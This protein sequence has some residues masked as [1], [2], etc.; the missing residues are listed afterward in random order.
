MV[1]EEHIERRIPVAAEVL[2]YVGGALAFAA[3]IALLS[4]FWGVMGIAGRLGVCALVAAAGL[5]GG[6]A[7]DHL[8]GATASRLKQFLFALGVAGLGAGFGLGAFEIAKSAGLTGTDASDWG[9]FTGFLT[10]AVAGGLIWRTRKTVLQHLV[11]GFSVGMSA[12]LSLPLMP[13]EGPDWGAGAVL[14]VVGV[15]WGVLGYRG[16]LPPQAAAYSLAS[17]GVLGGIEMMSVVWGAPELTFLSWALWLGLVVSVAMLA[18]GVVARNGVLLGFGS[19]GTVAFAWQVI[20]DLFEGRAVVPAGLLSVGIVFVG[21][22]FAI[23]RRRSAEELER[24]PLPAEVLGYVG[25]SLVAAGVV[26]LVTTFWGDLTSWGRVLIL[27]VPAIATL[28]AGMGISRRDEASA[29]RLGQFLCAL[30]IAGIGGAAGLTGY[31]VA[32][33]ISEPLPGAEPGELA[34]MSQS[35]GMTIGFAVAA[36][37]GG[38]VWFL[39]KGAL[40][41]LAMTAFSVMAVSTAFEIR[42]MFWFE[43]P[44]WWAS[45]TLVAIVSAAWLFLGIREVVTPANVPI[46]VGSVGLLIG[47]SS[48]YNTRG[49]PVEWMPWL[50]LA[51]SVGMLVASIPLKRYVLLGVG[52][53]GVVINAIQI[54][55]TMFEGAIGGPIVLLVAGVAFVAMAV[56]V[57]VAL[58][59][60]RGGR[61]SGTAHPA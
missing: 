16:L 19:L 42:P 51:I 7:M 35:W 27:A 49:G 40:T 20:F 31:E 3:L 59:R 15:V 43:G 1:E 17:L 39:R 24:I 22:A 5:G 46:S 56:F 4:Q 30:G 47:V 12:L 37:T 9:W 18:T 52:A 60:M 44:Y 25:G 61:T 32:L 28:A 48:M 26:S 21:V 41:A 8:H 11:F 13:I 6:Y 36:I 54:V 38:V 53:A 10:A 55:M 23:A 2:G 58:P 57:A 45:G 33:A 14:A 34:S 29:H 50:G